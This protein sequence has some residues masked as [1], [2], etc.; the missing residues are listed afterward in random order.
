MLWVN[1][2]PPSPTR[3]DQLP[4]QPTLPVDDTLCVPSA[5]IQVKNQIIKERS[6]F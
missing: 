1:P 4:N 6:Y 3:S 5:G 2:T